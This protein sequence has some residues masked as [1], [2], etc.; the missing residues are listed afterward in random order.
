MLF[1]VWRTEKRFICA[2]YDY[3]NIIINTIIG[4]G[5]HTL[6]HIIHAAV[7]VRSNNKNILNSTRFEWDFDGRDDAVHNLKMDLARERERERENE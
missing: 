5:N 1:T 3:A 6:W 2:L 7:Y 4:E